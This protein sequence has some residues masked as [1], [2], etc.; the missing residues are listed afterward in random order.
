M[1]AGAIWGKGGDAFEEY[2]EPKRGK[3]RKS[4]GRIDLWFTYQRED[5]KA[6][7]KQCWV[8]PHREKESLDHICE[9]MSL[10]KGDAGSLDGDGMQRLAIVFGAVMIP[11]NHAE[12]TG[13][14]LD[15]AIILAQDKKIGADAVAWT[16]P[17]LDKPLV[18]AKGRV[19]PGIIMWL[20]E[21]RRSP[22]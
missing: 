7:A 6:E 4:S 3:H 2:S 10:A 11:K 5:Y 21:V 22:R 12:R 13:E 17:K 8:R 18:D 14:L 16:F 9:V 1:L 15:A 20:K 19:Y